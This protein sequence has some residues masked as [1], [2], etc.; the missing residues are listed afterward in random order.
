MVQFFIPVFSRMVD[1]TIEKL[2]NRHSD[3]KPFDMIHYTERCTIEMILGSSFDAYLEDVSDGD[4]T[5]DQ[6]AGCV[7]T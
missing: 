2:K 4:K 7:K 3:G 1:K 5:M 6:I